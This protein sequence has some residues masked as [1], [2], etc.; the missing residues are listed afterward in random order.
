MLNRREAM[1]ALSAAALLTACDQ[2][3]KAVTGKKKA[4]GALFGSVEKLDPA[5]DAIVDANAQLEE[6]AKGFS[7]SEGPVWDAKRGQLYFSDVPENTAYRWSE[8]DGLQIF[9]KPSGL[10]EEQQTGDFP[11]S[12]GSNGLIMLRNG[13]LGVCNHGKRAVLSMDIDSKEEEILAQKF[14]GKLFNSPNDM[15]EHSDGSIFFTDPPYGLKEQ[16]ESTDKQLDFNGVYRLDGGGELALIDDTMTRPN[17]IALSPDEK[18]LYVAQSDADRQII[19]HYR[20][21]DERQ[22]AD[23]G[24]FFDC[25]PLSN[26]EAPGLPDGMCVHSS[27]IIFAT[28]P[29]GVLILSPDGKLLGR[30][31]CEKATANCCLGGPDGNTLFVTSSDRLARIGLKNM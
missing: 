14:Q 1:V 29:G 27:G 30:I 31:L 10:S 8:K 6:L 25:Q 11:S 15:V 13:K 24:V 4:G 16:D 22:V 12:E 26:N 18:T 2:G 28:G 23:A 3:S 19:K 17:G 5:L 21:S 7:W 9:L 20:L